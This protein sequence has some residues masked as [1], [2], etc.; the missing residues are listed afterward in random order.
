MR[1][2]SGLGYFIGY[3]ANTR[4]SYEHGRAVAAVELRHIA[5]L[6]ASKQEAMR[7]RAELFAFEQTELAEAQAALAD[8]KAAHLEKLRAIVIR[9]LKRGRDEL[10]GLQE[11]DADQIPGEV[12]VILRAVGEIL[13]QLDGVADTELLVRH[14]RL[15]DDIIQRLVEYLYP[16]RKLVSVDRTFAKDG[17]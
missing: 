6:N 3:L 8:E 10:L 1:R 15:R 4:A 11:Q 7:L 17:E 2:L 9:H 14:E 5:E 12:F 16:D 13:W